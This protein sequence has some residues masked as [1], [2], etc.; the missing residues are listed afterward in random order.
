MKGHIMIAAINQPYFMPYIGYW[1]LIAS[2]DLFAIADNYNYINKGWINRNRILNG[3]KIQYYNITIDHA[4]QNRYICDHDIKPIQPSDKEHKLKQ[5]RGAY[6]HA[7]YL[8]NG[9]EL[10]DRVFSFEGLNLADFL[11][12]SIQIVC[13]YLQIGTKLER[14]TDYVQDP[15]LRFADRVYDYCHQMGADTY[16]NPIGGLKLYSFEEFAEHGI[17]LA[18]LKSIPKPYPQSSENFEFGLSIIDVIMNNSFEE[19]QELL[20]SYRL[21]TE[22]EEPEA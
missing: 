9:L 15:S 13:D 5:L 22:P 20:K 6:C 4:S 21:I 14:T 11:F 10:M 8:E 18:F 19:I 2:A 17:Q 7:P 1:Q 16:H 12:N 3:N